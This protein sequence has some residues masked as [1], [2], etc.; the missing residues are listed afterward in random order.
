M[1][2]VKPLAGYW[3]AVDLRVDYKPQDRAA[4]SPKAL[5]G[6][7][8]WA[9]NPFL[10]GFGT[11]RFLADYMYDLWIAKKPGG[12]HGTVYIKGPE[13]WDEW[14]RE[15]SR[16]GLQE[17]RR[18][19]VIYQLQEEIMDYAPWVLVLNFMLPNTRAPTLVVAGFQLGRLI[20]LE[21]TLSFLGLGVESRTPAWGSM[22]SDARGYLKFAW[23]TAT[24][25]GI[26]IA[27]VVLA[28]NFMGDS[29][30]DRLDPALRN[31]P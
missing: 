26:A 13:H 5:R 18:R 25:P 12:S 21:A 19:E 11:G 30:R 31:N 15:I 1:R 27:L 14:T 29:L 10:M 28:A 3:E 7:P 9:T 17:P 16:L 20:L 6:S 22:L 8:A 4:Y 23:W 2:W 24:F